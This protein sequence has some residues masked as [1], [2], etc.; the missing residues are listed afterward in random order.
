MVAHFKVSAE[1]VPVHRITKE[2]VEDLL[3][4]RA[5]WFRQGKLRGEGRHFAA[6]PYCGNPIQFMGLYKRQENSPRPYGSHS[7]VAIEG[8]SFNALD[9]EYCPYKLKN[10]AHGKM[11]RRQMGP[12]AK[13][14]IE[15]AISEF[16]RIVLILRDDFGFNFSD[17][18]AEQML[19]QWFDSEAYLYTGAHLRNLPWMVAYFA[20]AMNLFGQLV[21]KNAELTCK[22]RAKVPQAK[23]SDSGRLDKGSSW[24]T[25]NLQC[26][27]HSVRIEEADGT[28]VESLTLRVQDFTEANEPSKA[29]IVY[30]KQIIFNPERF[31]A[32]IH[33]P[34]ERAK[35]NESL[36][37]RAQTIAKKWRCCHV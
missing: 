24:Y 37:M 32:L 22:I 17:A 34:P 13:Q 15:I 5:P 7:G 18:F 4:R 14:M 20:P 29:P 31:E 8:F 11:Q 3:G 36:L 23:I 10:L 33:T 27:H 2:N 9:L 25:L 26:L 19:E 35:R 12:I 16:D 28:L 6:C 21:A 30:R 1:H